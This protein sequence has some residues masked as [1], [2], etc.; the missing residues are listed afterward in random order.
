MSNQKCCTTCK[1]VYVNTMSDERYCDK[2]DGRPIKLWRKKRR[3]D[4]CP[5][6]AKSKE[7]RDE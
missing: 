7:G 6:L 2:D 4:W 3:P 5:L 1:Y